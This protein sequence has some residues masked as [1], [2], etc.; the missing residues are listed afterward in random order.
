MKDLIQCAAARGDFLHWLES[1]TAPAAAWKGEEAG[2]L[3]FKL[4]KAPSVNYLYRTSAAQDSGISW[5][6]SLLFCGVYEL[7]SRR[8]FLT[9]DASDA[10]MHGRAPLLAETGP[11]MLKAITGRINRRVEA[12]IAN[13]RRNLPVQEL[14][15]SRAV[16][17][18]EYYQEHGAQSEALRRLFD[19]R[20][21]DGQFHS[22]YTLDELPEAAFMAW[23]KNPEGF[24]QAEAEAYIKTNQEKFLLQFLE[25]DA[26]L[27]EYQALAQDTGNPV[28][29]MKAITDAV[30][31]SGAKT[32]T[33]TVQKEEGELTFKAQ[34]SSLTGQWASYSTYDIPAADRRAFEQV[35]GSHADYGP[36]DITKITYGRNTIYEAPPAQAV[37]MAE[38]MRMGG[39]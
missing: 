31:S 24:I 34:A 22:G 16:R 30:K 18:L 11:S 25:N 4:E 28:H 1:G 21:P 6:S 8:L 9:Q 32:V 7:Q 17:D 10:L 26:L 23:L 3:L 13:D 35:F 2:I 29:R 12:I 15:G 19:G 39:M 20:G 33:V 37:E 14:T 38:G 5:N 27:A 36:E